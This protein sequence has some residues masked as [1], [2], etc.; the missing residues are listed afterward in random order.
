MPT[1]MSLQLMDKSIK[2]PRGVIEDV[3][4]KVDK[5]YLL[6]DFIIREMEED[7]KVLVILGKSFLATGDTLIEIQQDKLTLHV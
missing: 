3:L 2:C 1:T 6:A 4:V 5:L 7:R